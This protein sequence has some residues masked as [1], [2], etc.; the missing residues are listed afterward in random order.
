MLA[1]T[2]GV[3]ARAAGK[4][5]HSVLL[6]VSQ[7]GPN[8]RQLGQA[9]LIPSNQRGDCLRLGRDCGAP[10]DEPALR[11]IVL[12]LSPLVRRAA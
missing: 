12:W 3:S 2:R 10:R 8:V 4:P 11:E 6:P 5:K 9:P 7:L 1:A